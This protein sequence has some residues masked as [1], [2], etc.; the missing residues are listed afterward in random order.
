VRDPKVRCDN[1]GCDWEETI[2]GYGLDGLFDWLDVKC[3]KCNG[4]LPIITEADLATTLMLNK[5]LGNPIVRFLGWI[6]GKLG[7]KS[8]VFE[9]HWSRK[10][11]GQVTLV[12]RKSEQD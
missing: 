6:S 11:D 5:I 12:E 8:R 10:G 2:T 3:P 7:G 4:E 9:T 1:P